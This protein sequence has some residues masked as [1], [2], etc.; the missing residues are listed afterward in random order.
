M[1]PR[2]L[3]AAILEEDFIVDKTTAQL[4]ALRDS[5][6]KRLEELKESFRRTQMMYG[7]GNMEDTTYEELEQ[8]FT[9]EQIKCERDLRQAV[10]TLNRPK[11]KDKAIERAAKQL[12]ELADLVRALEEGRDTLDVLERFE[13]VSQCRST[14][15]QMKPNAEIVFEIKKRLFD[16][17]ILAGG[18]IILSE[19]QIVIHG[20]VRTEDPEVFNEQILGTGRFG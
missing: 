11:A 8:E 3:K 19:D 9:A 10:N 15:K 12:V 2:V 14:K 13:I 4:K 18:R 1:D 20:K 5:S 16:D 17:L 7:T 6:A